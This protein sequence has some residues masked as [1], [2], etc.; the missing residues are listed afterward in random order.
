MIGLCIEVGVEGG[1]VGGWEVGVG[2]WRVPDAMRAKAG[3]ATT[4]ITNVAVD[5]T[6]GVEG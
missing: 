3:T 2:G 1:R 5:M 6:G 4:A